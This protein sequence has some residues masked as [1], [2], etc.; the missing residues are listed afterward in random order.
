MT[1]IMMIAQI[2]ILSA[3]ARKPSKPAGDGP[4]VH[5]E[6]IGGQKA[7]LPVSATISNRSNATTAMITTTHTA[8]ASQ[9]ASDKHAMMTPRRLRGCPAPARGVTAGLSSKA[10]A[11]R[12]PERGHAGGADLI[13]V[14]ELQHYHEL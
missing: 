8:I 10:G 6:V 2:T 3:A 5:G 14:R 7:P 11:E 13:P 1:A 12:T 9:N 4:G